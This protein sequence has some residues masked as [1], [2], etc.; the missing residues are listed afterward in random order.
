MNRKIITIF[1]FL[2]MGF[3]SNVYSNEIHTLIKKTAEGAWTVKY[4]L[5]KPVKR[6]IFIRSPD[7][8]R[9][10]R[11]YPMSSGFKIGYDSGSEHVYKTDGT[12]FKGVTIE[13]TP[14]YTA[15]P[16]DYAPFSPYS[17]GSILI[18][19]GRFFTCPENCDD[20]MNEWSFTLEANESDN[21]IVGGKIYTRVAHWVDE[22][23][24]KKVYVGKGKPIQDDNF[25]S[26]IDENLPK[27]LLNLMSNSLPIMV[28]YFKNKLGNLNY[29]PSLY[30]SYSNNDNGSYGNQGG[31]LPGQIFMHW[32]GQRALD[33]LDE[34]EM[35]WFF[36]HEVAHLYQGEAGR[37]TESSE[38]WLHEGGA[39]LFAGIANSDIEGDSA[40]LDRKL[41]IAESNCIENLKQE[42]DF[43]IAT[44]NNPK[45]H[46]SC[47][48]VLLNHINKELKNKQFDIFKAWALFNSAVKSGETASALTFLSVIKPYLSNELLNSLD[49]FISNEKFNSYIFFN[50]L[51]SHH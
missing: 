41:V 46:Y 23:D 32:Y 42:H 16:K 3:T 50:G 19:T 51:A 12:S 44:S 45:L 37:V 39:E 30:A 18:H 49:K 25:V 13:V 10:S 40:I 27:N 6:L 8:S 33:N 22:N 9:L 7:R 14:T 21:V 38:A 2:L 24:G 17:D 48:L 43:S 11:W 4:S 15:L 20:I 29:R 5:E 34:N 31:I 26:L 47:G 1:L 28:S 35:H 36:A